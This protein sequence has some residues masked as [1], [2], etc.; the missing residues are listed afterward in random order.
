MSLLQGPF[1]FQGTGA[2]AAVFACAILKMLS[3]SGRVFKVKKKKKKESL[4]YL[5]FKYFYKYLIN[6]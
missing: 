4:F 3:K 2:P 1:S 6:F 5:M